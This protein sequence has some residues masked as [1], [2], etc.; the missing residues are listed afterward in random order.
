VGGFIA[1]SVG[2]IAS[3]LIA[4]STGG[5]SLFA[6]IPD[7][8]S[9]TGDAPMDA[10]TKGKTGAEKL[11]SGAGGIKEAISAAGSILSFPKML[12]DIVSGKVQKADDEPYRKL[13]RELAEAVHAQLAARL[14][15]IQANDARKA[16]SA[17]VAQANLDLHAAQEQLLSASRDEHALRQA[18]DLLLASGQRHAD[19]L[20]SYLFQAAR[21]TEIY[22]LQDESGV[23]NFA[24]GRVHPDRRQDYDEQFTTAASFA[25]EVSASWA[26]I[27]DIMQY[28]IAYDK[29]RTT[30]DEVDGA[31]FVS[32]DDPNSIGQ[33]KINTEHN[34]LIDVSD[35]VNRFEAKVD[36][37]LVTLVG[38]KAAQPFI[39]VLVEHGGISQSL[40]KSGSTYTQVLRPRP[41]V[42]LPTRNGDQFSG[43]ISG[44]PQSIPFIGRGV[45]TTW[46]VS[47]D[48]AVAAH[49][50]VDLSGLQ[51]VELTVHYTS[52]L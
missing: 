18:A 50:G 45:A 4:I 28:R 21:A 3:T 19:M 8:V 42:S 43:V 10:V 46:R 2:L 37:V 1:A 51:R 30:F 9:L 29:Y 48:P 49:E 35:L 15:V 22:T 38:V 33:F 6:A 39:T 40:L 14:R 34:F 24:H 32:I 25:G 11:K 41:T 23:L 12:A 36:F 44:P 7:L 20:E 16:A 26:T 47:L 27:A 5:A 13:V 17:R 52:F 31:A